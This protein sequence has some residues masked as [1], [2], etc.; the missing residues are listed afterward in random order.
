MPRA[1]IGSPDPADKAQAIGLFGDAVSRETWARLER[2][3]DLLLIWQASRNLVAASTIP[4]LWTRHVADSLQ[5][6]A[7]APAARRW[8]DL[9]SGAG[10]PGLVIA[11][12]LADKP[13][14]EVHLI[15]SVQK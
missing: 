7:L 2:L 14:P 3:V 4:R 10:F 8:I 13:G 11:C 6:L 15:E 5:L 9:G 1:S 12:A